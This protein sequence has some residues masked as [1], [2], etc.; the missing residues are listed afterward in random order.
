M[1]DLLPSARPKHTRFAFKVVK[2]GSLWRLEEIDEFRPLPPTRKNK[3]ERE[4]IDPTERWW[5]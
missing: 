4:K 5:I 2:P 1:E 3:T